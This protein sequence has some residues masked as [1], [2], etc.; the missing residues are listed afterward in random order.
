M[1]SPKTPDYAGWLSLIQGKNVSRD[2]LVAVRASVGSY[3][4]FSHKQLH[5]AVEKNVAKLGYDA[6]LI[7]YI[8]ENLAGFH[9]DP[10]DIG[11]EFMVLRE[12]ESI[13]EK[14]GCDS[15]KV[16]NAYILSR[17]SEKY[18]LG[19]KPLVTYS[20]ERLRVYNVLLDGKL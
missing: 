2:L 13:G 10:L 19:I 18:N 1:M 15:I 16:P 5:D 17:I 4:N 6:S 3:S 14:L 20:S 11:T 7:E 8:Y 12:F 9:I